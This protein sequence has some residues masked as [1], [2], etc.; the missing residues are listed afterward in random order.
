[1]DTFKH[2]LQDFSV[3][4]NGQT[5]Y[6]HTYQTRQCGY[7]TYENTLYNQQCGR[8]T[9]EYTLHNPTMFPPIRFEHRN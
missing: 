5:A 1:M 9:Y 8:V 2:E 3:Y 7:V 4:P 6:E